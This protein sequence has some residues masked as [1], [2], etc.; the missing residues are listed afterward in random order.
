MVGF[1]GVLYFCALFGGL[2]GSAIP[3]WEY[4]SKQEKVSTIFNFVCNFSM[5]PDN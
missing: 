2:Q 5:T 1:A 3:I 4:L